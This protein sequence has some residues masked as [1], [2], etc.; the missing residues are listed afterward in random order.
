MHPL[1]T[2]LFSTAAVFVS[3]PEEARV[4]NAM[5]EAAYSLVNHPL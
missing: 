1:R 5:I 4:A 3:P 2:I